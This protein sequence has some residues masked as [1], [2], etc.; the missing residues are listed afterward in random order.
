MILKQK[1]SAIVRLMT[2]TNHAIDDD[3]YEELLGEYKHMSE[4]MLIEINDMHNVTE[5][6]D[7]RIGNLLEYIKML[8]HKLDA[9][10]N[11]PAQ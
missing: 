9:C 1:S 3:K 10:K 7:I 5:K 8:E 2:S 11:Q 6:Q 4:V